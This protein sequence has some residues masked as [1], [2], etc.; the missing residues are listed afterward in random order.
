M[1]TYQTIYEYKRLIKLYKI[2]NYIK[3]NNCQ[4]HFLDFSKDKTF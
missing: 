1:S 3:Y 4:N 2:I